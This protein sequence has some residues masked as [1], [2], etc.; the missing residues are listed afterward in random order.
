MATAAKAYLVE[1]AEER[2]DPQTAHTPFPGTLAG[3]LDALGAARYR[4]AAGSPKVV[5]VVEGRQRTVIRSFEGGTE[6]WSAS[7]AQIRH[8]RAEGPQG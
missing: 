1:D 7:R 6:V 4:S 8:E 2:S 5:V 3:L